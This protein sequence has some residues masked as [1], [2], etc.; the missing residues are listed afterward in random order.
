MKTTSLLTL[1]TITLF[2]TLSYAQL[3]S[4]RP[5]G[6][7][8][9]GV[10][11]GIDEIDEDYNQPGII[12]DRLDDR[13]DDRFD[14]RLDQTRQLR[15][16][17]NLH[18]QEF[19]SRQGEDTIALKALIQRQYGH[20][21]LERMDLKKVIVLAKSQAGRA[22]M[23]LLTGH[24]MSGAQTIAGN[25]HA[26]HRRGVGFQRYIFQSRGLEGRGVWQLKIQGNVKVARIMIV[27]GEKMR[28]H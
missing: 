26:Y 3:G 22:Q 17:L 15:L 11:G 14:D 23:S 13:Y 6:P 20:L 10:I 18:E 27:L 16:E 28:R 7:I 12:D 8:D 5:I 21:P 9:D 4:I 2:S 1:L 25:H 24:E 19:N